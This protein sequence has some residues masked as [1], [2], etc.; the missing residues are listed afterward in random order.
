MSKISVPNRADLSLKFD[1]G[2]MNVS[3]IEGRIGIDG[4]DVEL[5]MSKIKSDRLEIDNDDGSI[6]VRS[7]E[8]GIKI[9]S[10]DTDVFLKEVKSHNIS[11]STDD[12]DIDVETMVEKDGIYEFVTDDGDITLRIPEN[13]ALKVLADKD[14]G[15]FLS[16]LPIKGSINP[17]KVEGIIG[18]EGGKVYIST[19]DGDIEISKWKREK[20]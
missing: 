15:E 3:E 17:R 20:N 7:F 11:I 5:T 1:D 9:I 16:S 14:D 12:G 6:E 18:S 4:D 8:G 2:V 19:D 13:A 10:D